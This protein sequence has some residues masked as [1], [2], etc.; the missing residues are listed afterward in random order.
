MSNY[1]KVELR[2]RL[3]DSRRNMDLS[4]WQTLSDRLCQNILSFLPTDR[5]LTLLGYQSFRQEPD[6]SYLFWIDRFRWGMPRCVDRSLAWHQWQ[7]GDE[8]NCDRYGIRTPHLTAPIILPA[9]VDFSLVPCVGADR[10]GYRL[11][12]GGGYYD[13]LFADP[14][15]QQIPTIGIVFEDGYMDRLP[16]DDWD[17]P[18]DFICTESGIFPAIE[19]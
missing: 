13:R 1:S 5:S 14:Q 11:G 7:L 16:I 3:L 9:T 4:R 6:L 12:Y 2:D 19:I 18:L 8:L 15:W 17:R 10:F